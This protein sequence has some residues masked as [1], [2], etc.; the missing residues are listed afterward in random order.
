VASLCE[1]SKG[2]SQGKELVSKIITGL[3]VVVRSKI[4]YIGCDE[5][6]KHLF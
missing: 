5:M 2:L 3:S 4:S 6:A 1:H